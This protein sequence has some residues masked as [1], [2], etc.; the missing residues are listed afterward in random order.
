MMVLVA[1]PA[2]LSC[3]LLAAHFLHANLIPAVAVSLL[4]P[5]FLIG[6]R[7]TLVRLVQFA[8]MAGALEWLHTAYVLIGE[9]QAES[10]P[11][12]RLAVIMIGVELFTI[13]SAVLLNKLLPAGDAPAAKKDFADKDL[14]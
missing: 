14:A 13:V 6:R 4:L 10:R 12:T 11:W 5:F 9:R 1:I 2:I 7:Y 3:L 8:L